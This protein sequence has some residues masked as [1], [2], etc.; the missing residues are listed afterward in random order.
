MRLTK[1]V[2]PAV[3]FNRRAIQSVGDGPD[4]AARRGVSQGKST[5]GSCTSAQPTPALPASHR[6]RTPRRCSPFAL[7]KRS[8]LSKLVDLLFSNC[9]AGGTGMRRQ[10]PKIFTDRDRYKLSLRHGQPI[11][12]VQKVDLSQTSRTDIA[13]SAAR[14]QDEG[15]HNIR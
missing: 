4:R 8:N 6:E 12:C 1:R 5:G 15:P 13:P 2:F 3:G 9:G 10:K 14:Y 7:E 11:W